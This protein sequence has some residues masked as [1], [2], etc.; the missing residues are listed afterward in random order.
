MFTGRALVLFCAAALALSAF[1]GCNYNRP[2]AGVQLDTYGRII[3]GDPTLAG[4]VIGRKI[5]A[6]AQEY[7]AAGWTMRVIFDREPVFDH[8]DLAERPKKVAPIVCTRESLF[9]RGYGWFFDGPVK[10]TVQAVQVSAGV[11]EG[12]EAAAAVARGPEG[13]QEAIVAALQPYVVAEFMEDCTVTVQGS[14]LPPE[15]Y[16]R[17]AEAWRRP[18][19]RELSSGLR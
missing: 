8:P 4:Q 10:V 19:P 14:S 18:L 1:T 9:D 17:L 16:A 13:L 5:V 11:N 7:V 12:D 2:I 3:D 15:Q 6:A